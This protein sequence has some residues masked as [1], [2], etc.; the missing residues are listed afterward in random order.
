MKIAFDIDGVVLQSIDFILDHINREKGLN[1]T[2]DELFTWDLDEIGVDSETLRKAI[3]KMYT[4]PI[5]KPYTRAEEVLSLVHQKTK[6]PLLF[7]TG[8]SDPQTAAI[9]LEKLS[10]NSNAPQMVVTGGNRYKMPYIQETEAEFIIEDDPEHLEAYLDAGI[11]VGLMIRP[12]N[13]NCSIPVNERFESWDDVEKWFLS[14][15]QQP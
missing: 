5:V 1:I 9:Q 4:L 13:R 7:I 15:K 14:L 12:W 2:P 3:L 10:W 11:G 6:E 8:R